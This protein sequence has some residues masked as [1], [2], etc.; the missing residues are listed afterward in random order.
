MRY[1]LSDLS[2]LYNQKQPET[3]LLRLKDTWNEERDGSALKDLS[4]RHRKSRARTT[5]KWQ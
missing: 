3:I 1:K 4:C 2:I 5:Q